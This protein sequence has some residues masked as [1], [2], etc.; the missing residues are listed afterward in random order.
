MASLLSH[1]SVSHM[2]KGSELTTWGYITYWGGHSP[3]RSLTIPLLAATGHLS[4]FIQ[5]WGLVKFCPTP[6]P[7]DGGCHHAGLL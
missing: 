1:F 2:Y 3:W 4:F 6:W 7:V 5:G